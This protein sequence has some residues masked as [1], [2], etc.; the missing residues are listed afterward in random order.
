MTTPRIS[1]LL[2]CFNDGAWI[3][4]ALQSVLEQTFQDFEIVVVDD[5]STDAATV[6]KLR[7]LNIPQVRL[8]ESVNQGLPA[9][10]NH[11]A[12]HARGDLFCALDADDR[13][14]PAW[15]EKGTMLLDSRPDLA[16]VSHWLDTFGDEC[17]TWRP[18]RC[19]LPALLA[20][21]TVN[22]AA[23]VRRAAF[24]AVGGYDESMRQ[25][26]EDWD[27][28]LRL[29]EAGHQG[30]I[31]PEV[32]FYYRRRAESM[33]RVMSTS[34]AYRGPLDVL[35][36]KHLRSY[37][38][39]LAGVIVAKEAE[40]LALAEEVSA[41]ERDRLLVLEPAMERAAEEL[42]AVRAREA[43]ARVAR[44]AEEERERLSAQVKELHREAADLRDSWSWRVTAPLRW[45]YSRLFGVDG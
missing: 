2:P 40:R 23:L 7:T 37:R 21:N 27:F 15:F 35:L 28:W 39:H 43:R 4:D 9:A 38:D 30:A 10:R 16:F 5:G 25:G 36:N 29:V 19:D 13:L 45:V 26:C 3:N 20:R 12:A 24:E 41:L 17:W 11:A 42:R 32:L 31:I 6:R 34:A 44:A 1:V 14:A 18:E 33:S 8:L 22:G